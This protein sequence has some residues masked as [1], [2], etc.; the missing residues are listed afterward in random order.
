MNDSEELDSENKQI[1][2]VEQQRMFE[3]VDCEMEYICDVL[4]ELKKETAAG[5]Y[6]ICFR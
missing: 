3:I 5:M 2:N 6:S 4:F 1:K